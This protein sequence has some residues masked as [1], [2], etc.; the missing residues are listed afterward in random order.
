MTGIR[1]HHM[2]TASGL[3]DY[4]YQNLSNLTMGMK[5]LNQTELVNKF[6][7]PTEIME[8]FK[9]KFVSYDLNVYILND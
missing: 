9:S 1:Q 6:P 4:D 2:P 8:H 7:I 5:N 3:S